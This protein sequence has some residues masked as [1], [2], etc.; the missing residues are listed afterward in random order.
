MVDVLSFQLYLTTNTLLL[1]INMPPIHIKI[2]KKNYSSL[3]NKIISF[4]DK[5]LLIYG[6][7][8]NVV[9]PSYDYFNPALKRSLALS[10]LLRS[11]DL[12]DVQ[13][14]FYDSEKDYFLF[15][16]SEGLLKDK[17]VPCRQNVFS[18]QQ[19]EFKLASSPRLGMPQQ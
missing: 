9:D 2:N 5:N 10:S 13:R 4:K 15:L 18:I 17:P 7:L 1:S 16:C 8:N 3:M 6:D 11:E 12:F 14:C 19:L